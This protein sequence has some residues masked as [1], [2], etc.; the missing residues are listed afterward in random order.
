MCLRIESIAKF[1]EYDIPCYK[2]LEECKL[3]WY[4]YMSPFVEQPIN[5][6]IMIGLYPYV[7]LGNRSIKHIN[8]FT[9]VSEGYIHTYKSK[10]VAEEMCQYFTKHFENDCHLFECKIPAGTEY[11]EGLDDNFLA[12]YASDKIVFVSEI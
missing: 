1:A 3:E 9:S 11:Y 2:V 8:G 12:S 4:P 5:A 6:S 7:G 10:T